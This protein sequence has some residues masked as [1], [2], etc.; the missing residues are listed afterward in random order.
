MGALLVSFVVGSII[1]VPFL[2]YHLLRTRR[3]LNELRA[4]LRRRGLIAPRADTAPARGSPG[5]AEPLAGAA[6]GPR[7]IAAA[8]P[9]PVPG[10][11][12]ALPVPHVGVAPSEER[13]G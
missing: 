11:P 4:E 8:P 5:P 6:A 2:G 9:Q 13:A 12:A 7:P 1:G 10:H 3:E